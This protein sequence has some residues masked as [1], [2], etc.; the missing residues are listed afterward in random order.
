MPW[1]LLISSLSPLPTT[2]PLSHTLSLSLTAKGRKRRR[3]EKKL[4]P[5]CTVFPTPLLFRPCPFFY[6]PP[7]LILV[8]PFFPT[9]PPKTKLLAPSSLGPYIIPFGGHNTSGRNFFF[10]IKVTAT[11]PPFLCLPLYPS[12]TSHSP[13]D[14]GPL[15]HSICSLPV[16]RKEG[17]T[18]LGASIILN[19]NS[20][21]YFYCHPL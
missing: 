20:S 15:T 2:L 14:L 21:D 18:N 7:S 12:L 6:S 10:S 3:K 9:L 4:F 11:L 8:L 13:E 5:A 17:R 19:S 1:E 16:S